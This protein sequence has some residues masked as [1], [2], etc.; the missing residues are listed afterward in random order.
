M[1]ATGG[2]AEL[3]RLEGESGEFKCPDAGG[4]ALVW[5]IIGASSKSAAAAAAAADDDDDDD[6]GTKPSKEACIRSEV[7]CAKYS[8]VSVSSLAVVT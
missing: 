7:T 1:V 5:K 8:G 2:V 6:D 3:S 4:A